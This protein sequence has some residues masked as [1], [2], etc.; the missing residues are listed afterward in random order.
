MSRCLTILAIIIII[1][2][3]LIPAV[4]A[5][6]YSFPSFNISVSLDEKGNM[7]E[8]TS[9]IIKNLGENE[10]SEI[11]YSFAMKPIEF[12]AFDTKGELEYYFEEESCVVI[13][14][15][16]PLSSGEEVKIT[17]NYVIP[18]MVVEYRGAKMLTFSYVP[19]TEI[20]DF[21][22]IVALP[23]GGT[24][25][26][27]IKKGGES[28][29]AISPTPNRIYSDG[30]RIII[31]W[32]RK[33]MKPGDNFRI[34]F[35]YK[36]ISERKIKYIALIFVGMLIG[37][38]ITFFVV[39]GRKKEQKIAKLVLNEEEQKI[40]DLIIERGGV[41]LQDEIVKEL[42]YSKAKVS[43]IVRKLEEKGIIRKEPYKKTNKL[44]LRKEFGGKY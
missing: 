44:Y 29:S 3:L 5:E 2:F 42:D 18:D 22:V 9:F 14:L 1:L 4:H 12:S 6:E 17:M 32:N 40:F 13:K 30:E 7:H 23:K 38:G 28:I 24:L 25:V 10:I 37:S 33:N 27:D 8:K 16:K 21:N 19:T 15:R 35:T 39:K 34:V 20:E 36:M 11:E 31:M 41:I 26:S 43:K